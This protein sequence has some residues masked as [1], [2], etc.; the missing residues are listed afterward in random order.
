MG[1]KLH[2]LWQVEVEV[3]EKVA[4]ETVIGNGV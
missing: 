4:W 3:V 1:R 2:E